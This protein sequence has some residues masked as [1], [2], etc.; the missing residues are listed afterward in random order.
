MCGY[1][2]Y[3]ASHDVPMRRSFPI[4]VADL[5]IAVYSSSAGVVPNGSPR[6]RNASIPTISMHDDVIFKFAWI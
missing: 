3:D 5:L 6:H 2:S 1:W 4:S